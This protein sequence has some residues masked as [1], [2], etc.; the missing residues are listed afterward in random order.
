MEVDLSQ[1][2]MA[3]F[4]QK[5]QKFSDIFTLM[6]LFSFRAQP[7][8]SGEGTSFTSLLFYDLVL[9]TEVKSKLSGT[10]KS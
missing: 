3:I 1:A 10:V 7:L 6:F 9:N 2:C 8:E 4:C 5:M